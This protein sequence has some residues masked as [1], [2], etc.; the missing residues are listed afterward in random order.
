MKY[1]YEKWFGKIAIPFWNYEDVDTYLKDKNSIIN[2]CCNTLGYKKDDGF[3]EGIVNS[4][5]QAVEVMPNLMIVYLVSQLEEMFRE[6][7]TEIFLHKPE[8]LN[9]CK[10]IFKDEAEIKLKFSLPE[11]I[12]FESKEAYMS[13][14]AQR[15]AELCINGSFR[16]VLQRLEKM[17]KETGDKICFDKKDIDILVDFQNKRNQIVH[18]NKLEKV[19]ILEIT[20]MDENDEI[21]LNSVANILHKI[22]KILKQLGFDVSI[23]ED[24]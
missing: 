10:E 4:I 18:E 19:N 17:S 8:L 5:N 15:G 20:E 24:L 7:F 2:H 22:T 6:L 16:N 11:L 1:F 3:T 12:K 9:K 21:K 23:P 13:V 14:L